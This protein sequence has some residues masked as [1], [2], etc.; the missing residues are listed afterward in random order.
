MQIH[1]LQIAND[2]LRE[3]SILR[4]TT[5]AGEEYR[6]CLARRFPRER[7]P[8]LAALLGKLTTPAPAMA[9]MGVA[10]QTRFEQ[11]H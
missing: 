6:I 11:P 9:G 8:H 1:Q 5:Q 3:R 4:V 7:W 2:H 10:E